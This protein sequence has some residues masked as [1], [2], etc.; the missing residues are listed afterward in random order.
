M[1]SNTRHTPGDMHHNNAEFINITAVHR[2]CTRPTGSAQ[3]ARRVACGN[4]HPAMLWISPWLLA[5]AS[6]SHCQRTFPWC[7]LPAARR[8]ERWRWW[9]AWWRTRAQTPGLTPRSVT[10]IACIP[11]WITNLYFLSSLMLL[12][13]AI[14]C[15]R[16]DSLLTCRMWFCM[17]VS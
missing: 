9:T 3:W 12:Y 14:L 15:S 11:I 1:K 5:C 17:T 2:I 8:R 10:C 13:S 16:A 7:F 6:G 4:P